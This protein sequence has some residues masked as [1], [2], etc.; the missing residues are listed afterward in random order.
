MMQLLREAF[1]DDPVMSNEDAEVLKRDDTFTQTVA[2]FLRDFSNG[3]D[4][5]PSSI[6]SDHMHCVSYPDDAAEPPK[7]YWVWEAADTH[8]DHRLEK[9][10]FSTL[11]LME[12]G[13]PQISFM[14]SP[15]MKYDHSGRSE[16]S[17]L[18][19]PI[20]YAA[21]GYGSFI[22]MLFMGKQNGYYTLEHGLKNR[23]SKLDAT[24]KMTTRN[25]DFLWDS[26]PTKQITV[27]QGEHMYE[28]TVKDTYLLLKE[29]GSEYPKLER[30]DGSQ[31]YALMA[32]GAVDISWTFANGLY[33]KEGIRQSIVDHAAGALL[34]SEAGAKVID[35]N[36]KPI[37]WSNGRELIGRSIL[38]F[39]PKVVA[40]DGLLRAIDAAT[41]QSEKDFEHF[42]QL[43]KENAEFFR[44]MMKHLPESC[45][46]DDELKRAKLVQARWEKENASDEAEFFN[47]AATEHLHEFE[48]DSYSPDPAP[49]S[50]RDPF[51]GGKFPYSP[52]IS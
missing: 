42:K 37:D 18:G 27:A 43:R 12:D 21:K 1:P 34:A 52:F 9:T 46:T 36:G 50:T 8:S 45:E 19:V 2:N 16:P 31:K 5:D 15:V 11:C 23:S 40:F 38:A 29:M 28:Y 7:R 47:N 49:E 35:F 6:A 3:T 32:M 22:Q 10:F 25:R 48:P 14:A 17:Q 41:E 26:L 51:A 24:T 44:K 20:F 33:V 13:E 30:H 39:D 4:F